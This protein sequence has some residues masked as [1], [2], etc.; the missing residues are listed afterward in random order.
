MKQNTATERE[1]LERINARQNAANLF[2]N[3]TPADIAREIETMNE[4]Q[5][6]EV[7]P[8]NNRLYLSNWPYNA[9]L[10]IEE[11]AAIVTNAGGTVKPGAPTD[12]TN[13]TL[14]S[15]KREQDARLQ[16]LEAIEADHPGA[17][18]KRTAAISQL[19]ADIER[20]A[21]IDNTPRTVH[22]CTWSS[23]YIS[24]TLDGMYYYYQ[25]DD[26]PLFPFHYQKTPIDGNNT[27]SRDAVAEEDNKEWL[28]DCFWRS[29]A[30]DA[31]RR[32]A[33]NILFN[34]LVK[35]RPSV[36]RRD[37]TRRRV[38]NSYNSGYHYETV[39]SPERREAVNF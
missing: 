21:R 26:N 11:L 15:M 12:I 33:A 30:T 19:R 3:I 13:R 4:E 5:K 9:A 16:Q 27:I 39:Y 34:M 37:R 25:T 20:A 31:D 23:A 6:E 8:M 18:E 24:F 1:A 32:E 38:R 17:N 28:W 29:D 22:H 35:A 14:D 36:I 7:T 2:T 10:I